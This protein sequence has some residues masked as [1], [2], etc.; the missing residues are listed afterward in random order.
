MS[1][2]LTLWPSVDRWL[3]PVCD[4]DWDTTKKSPMYNHCLR[5][6]L[7]LGD[8]DHPRRQPVVVAMA[9]DEARARHLCPEYVAI[10]ERI[11][12]K[13]VAPDDVAPGLVQPGD[14]EA[15]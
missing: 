1:A 8:I 6:G 10:L 2:Q 14:K 11:H 15:R 3:Y 7:R 12:R 4:H 13:L 9:I 5:C